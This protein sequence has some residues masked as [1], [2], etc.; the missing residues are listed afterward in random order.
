MNEH[1]HIVSIGASAGGI[2]EIASF[3]D[4]KPLDGVSYVVIQHLSPDFRTRMAELLARHL[5][6]V[7]RE[8]ENG[9]MVE[10]DHVYLIPN[11]QYMTILK[12]RLYITG[13]A[14]GQH[15]HLTIDKFFSSLAADQ[16]EK[17]IGIILSGMGKD[18]TEGIVSISSAGGM[19]IAR[20]PETTQF[21]S[22]PA[23][24]IATGAVD[25]VT[26]P[27][28]MP[29]LIED[30]VLQSRR[31]L[32]DQNEKMSMQTVLELIRDNT[33]FDFS[34]YKQATLSRRTRKRAINQNFSSLADYLSFLKVTPQEMNALAGEFLISV[35][36]FFRDQEAF[37][38]LGTSV[39]AG[40]LKKIPAGE[41]LKIWVPGC[42]TG[43]EAYSIGMLIS[44][45]LMDNPKEIT[46]KIF[47]TD[48]DSAAL[49]HAGKG[50]YTAVAIREISGE[51][52]ERFF[53]RQGNDYKITPELRRMVI[54][55]QHDLVRNPPYCN[56]D[57]ISCRNLLI[58]LSPSLQKKV[59]AM[60]LFGLKVEGHI[61]LG[62]SEN[63]SPIV[64]TL[65]VVNKKWKI[66][67]K[68]SASRI[69]NF[70]TFSL[71][72]FGD[73]KRLDSQKIWEGPKTV[74]GT[75][76]EAINIAL[77]NEAGGLIV[78]IDASNQV[79][80]SYG[81]TSGFLFQKNFNSN[82]TELLP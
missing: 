80:R 21:G 16:G 50:I 81:D 10:T 76:T 38:F 11:D 7:I 27:E 56:I 24:A 63:P 77:A 61:L 47:A 19:T 23:N 22:M 46:I 8:A 66:Y 37:D 45:Q 58:Y 52:L 30:Y 72:E 1:H 32:Q 73:T 9:M 62:S 78:C 42:A 5:H 13:K 17:A 41:E 15:P 20:N 36:A 14:S 71:P 3:F 49:K 35:T 25:F 34:G 31:A 6:L 18:G 29:A 53:T 33:A 82:L 55:A 67:K 51:R 59:L 4:Q 64:K 48:I 75:L 60:L 69:V 12:G 57:L 68:L 26:E 70:E 43:E 54:F 74:N 44:E 79:I 39:I 40:M 2:E 65:H 28:L